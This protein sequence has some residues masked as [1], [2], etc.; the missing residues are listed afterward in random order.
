[1]AADGDHGGGGPGRPACPGGNRCVGYSVALRYLFNQ[2]Q[3]WADELV[4]LLMVSLVMLGVADALR[5]G[6][7]IEV[8]LLTERLGPRGRRLAKLWGLAA[9]A[10]VAGV[11]LGGGLE[12]VIFSADVG[13]IADGYLEVPMWI[14][15]IAV[16]LGGG[17]LLL[18]A[19]SRLVAE[20]AGRSDDNVE[21]TRQ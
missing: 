1:M 14:P 11:I 10:L 4:G 3:V 15:Q 9:S 17:L 8:D 5:R 19:L 2:P 16:P 20:L 21:D 13:L 7:H 12:M 18:T 6:E